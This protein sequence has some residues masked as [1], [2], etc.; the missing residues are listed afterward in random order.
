MSGDAPGAWGHRGS[1]EPPDHSQR[2]TPDLSA[3]SVP[4]GAGA[5]AAAAAARGLGVG[6][7]GLWRQ[8]TGGDPGVGGTRHPGGTGPRRGPRRRGRLGRRRGPS[9]R[10][11]APA[12]ALARPLAR[13]RPGSGTHLA[14]SSSGVS[15]H[16]AAKCAVTALGA[17]AAAAG[18]APRRAS[19]SRATQRRGSRSSF[20]ARARAMARTGKRGPPR[21]S[22]RPPVR[23]A[24]FRSASRS[25]LPGRSPACACV[26][27]GVRGL[28][29]G[30][31]RP[32]TPE[33]GSVRGG[34]GVLGLKPGTLTAS[35][36]PEH[37]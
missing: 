4:G 5:A 10:R 35:A 8:Q 17:A 20:E 24:H 21:Y 9:A 14:S 3:H 37:P 36:A 32:P 12:S 16:L 18:L 6:G 30:S 26:V 15:G 28:G 7:L 13:L 23:P 2:G 25:P 11:H 27:A 33:L 31:P 22:R 29:V 19:P 1:R 34:L